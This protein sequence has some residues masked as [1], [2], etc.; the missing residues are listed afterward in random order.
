MRFFSI[1]FFTILLSL[2]VFAY[3]NSGTK[4][5]AENFTG[6]SLDG[7]IINL[8]DLRGKVVV[9]SFWT[10]RCA[11]CAAEVPKLNKLAD[12]YK[13]KNVVFLGLTTDNEAK[14]KDYL[15]KKPFNFN[16]LPNSF[17]TLLKYADRDGSG[18]VNMGY[19][20]HYLI[21]QKG[22]IELK[23]NGFDK[24]GLLDSNI[25]RLLMPN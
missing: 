18:N 24:A 13:G 5:L 10:T 19:P 15:R 14:V 22:E 2:S 20:T 7:T 6:I 4:P 1:L 3:S 23:T 16:I 9:V 11:I 12:A 17:G 25:R 8:A 21:N